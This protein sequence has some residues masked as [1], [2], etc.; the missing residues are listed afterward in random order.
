MKKAALFDLPF[1]WSYNPG[2]RKFVTLSRAQVFLGY[3]FYPRL[4]NIYINLVE[5]IA[6]KNY[7]YISSIAESKLASKIFEEMKAI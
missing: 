7:R 3:N 1:L 5:A 6:K 2:K 4:N